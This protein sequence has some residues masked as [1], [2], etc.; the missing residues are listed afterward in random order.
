MRWHAGRPDT[1]SKTSASRQVCRTP[2]EGVCVHK[3]DSTVYLA[4]QGKC[5]MHSQTGWN[6]LKNVLDFH[7][8]RTTYWCIGFVQFALSGV[9]IFCIILHQGHLFWLGFFHCNPVWQLCPCGKL[10]NVNLFLFQCSIS[11]S[12]LRLIF[13]C[14]YVCVRASMHGLLCIGACMHVYAWYKTY[15]YRCVSSIHIFWFP[16]VF[17]GLTDHSDKWN[18][19]FLIHALAIGNI[20]VMFYY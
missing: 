14:Q 17:A 12:M 11:M 3:T 5:G 8:Q 9:R 7:W 16:M 20:C 6:L 18:T 2:I 15:L 13:L 10:A 19:P 1:S 4:G